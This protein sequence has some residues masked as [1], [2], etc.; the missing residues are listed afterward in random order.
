MVLSRQVQ[1]RKG[2]A[3]VAVADSIQVG[4]CNVVPPVPS[5]TPFV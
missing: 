4:R 3:N 5:T 2:M 1:G